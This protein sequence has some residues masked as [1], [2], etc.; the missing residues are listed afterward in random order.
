MLIVAFVEEEEQDWLPTDADHTVHK[1]GFGVKEMKEL[2]EGQGLGG[3][4]W[5][6]MPERVELKLHEDK[7]IS[8]KGFLA[9]AA[10]M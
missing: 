5:K 3:F 8:R 4:G 2:M 6:E 1:H 9:R 10:K 7:P